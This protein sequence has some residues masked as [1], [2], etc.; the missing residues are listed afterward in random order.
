MSI[1]DVEFRDADGNVVAVASFAP[2]WEYESF[3]SA[4]EALI[5]LQTAVAADLYEVDV[6]QEPAKG[7]LSAQTERLIR[8]LSLPVEGE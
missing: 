6:T 2:G 1:Q 3:E 5:V 4:R 8:G 7:L